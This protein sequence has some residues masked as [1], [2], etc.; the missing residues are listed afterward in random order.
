MEERKEL[1]GKELEDAKKKQNQ[2]LSEQMLKE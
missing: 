2:S 1:K